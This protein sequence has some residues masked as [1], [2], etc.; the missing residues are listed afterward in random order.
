MPTPREVAAV[1]A[2]GLLGAPARYGIARALP[3]APGHWPTG[4]FLTNLLGA[5]A[6]G[7]LLEQLAWRGPRPLLRLF[8]GTGFIGAFTT[9]STLAVEADLLVR[10]GHPVLAVA[11]PL[12]S[13]VAGLLAT[14]A[15]VVLTG[16][17]APLDA[18]PDAP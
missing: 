17:R 7:F 3:T 15:G 12:V 8:V 13:L 6:L 16:R 9:A 18:D 4:T 11:Y 1:A 10:G 2:G 14:F 5:F